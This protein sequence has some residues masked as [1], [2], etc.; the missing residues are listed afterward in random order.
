MK[1]KKGYLVESVE[2]QEKPALLQARSYKLDILFFC[3]LFHREQNN[4]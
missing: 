3:A 4:F 1:E 2:T